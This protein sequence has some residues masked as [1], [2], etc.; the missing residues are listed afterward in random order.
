M[1]TTENPPPPPT[2]SMGIDPYERNWIVVGVGILVLFMAGITIAG[3]ALGYQLP[4]PEGRVDPQTVLSE[5]PFA[6]PGV[7]QISDDRFEAYVVARQF[8]YDPNVIEIPAGA[9]IDIFVTSP[10]VQHGFKVTDTNINMQIVPGQISKLSFTFDEVGE[11]PIICHEYCGLGHAAMF[12][13]VRVVP[14]TDFEGAS[15]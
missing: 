10:D 3:F 4:G 7:R 15:S 11:Y 1:T 14:P 9:T 6:E 2:N 12:G 8:L 5:G 13:T